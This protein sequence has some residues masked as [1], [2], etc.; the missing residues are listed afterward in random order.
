MQ[1]AATKAM[2]LCIGEERR[3]RR[4]LA[5]P[6]PPAVAGLLPLVPSQ[7]RRFFST[8]VPLGRVCKRPDTTPASIFQQPARPSR[9][10]LEASGGSSSR[11][12]GAGT[13]FRR[14][15]GRLACPFSARM[16]HGKQRPFGEKRA[17]F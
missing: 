4:R 15:L 5:P 8:E 9:E 11:R 12:D 16:R 6:Q 7:R 13:P 14:L 2:P 17:G 3:R 10:R 1:G